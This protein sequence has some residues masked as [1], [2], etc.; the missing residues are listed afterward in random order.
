MT[1]VGARRRIAEGEATRA[2]RRADAPKRS[3]ASARGHSPLRRFR[4]AYAE[5]RAAEGRGDGGEA[6]LLA[7]PYISRGPRAAQWRIRA[8]TFDRFVRSVLAP[9]ARRRA[10]RPLRVLDLGAGNGWLCHRVA[11]HGHRAAAVDLRDDEVDGLGA[12]VGYSAHL[13]ARMFDRI[14]ASFEALP[15]ADDSFDVV[16]FNASLHYALDLRTALAEAARVV[17]PGGRVAILDSPFYR[18]NDAGDAMVAEKRERAA[19]RFG[20]RA[21]AL[22]A[23]SF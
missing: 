2:G 13:G 3:L 5:Q 18:S 10:P 16:V 19:D 17:A 7:L 6:E 9:L 15:L 8:R 14:A 11:R 12:A 22:T 23:L 1:C 21:D 20:E 4:E